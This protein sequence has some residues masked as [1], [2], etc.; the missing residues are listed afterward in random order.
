MRRLNEIGD[1][2]LE[3]LLAGNGP[4]GGQERD[5]LA[6]FIMQA[7]KASSIPP[8]PVT[9]ERHISAIVRT[10]QLSADKGEPGASPA[11][12]AFGPESQVSGLPKRR[13][14][15]VLNSV[16][17]SLVAKVLAVGMVLAAAT[18]ALAATGNLPDE[19]QN[20]IS[21]A[22]EALGIQIPPGDSLIESAEDSAEDLDDAVTDE[23]SKVA[24][25]DLL[26][27][28]EEGDEGTDSETGDEEKT[29]GGDPEAGKR[30]NFDVHAAIE[31]TE[32]GPERGKAVS[33]AARQK[34][35]DEGSGGELGDEE[36][37]DDAADE[38]GSSD[39]G[40]GTPQ[41]N[42]YGHSKH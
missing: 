21:T 26:D 3:R 12:K 35:G 32:P 10:A 14:N 38:N 31:A 25:D 9:V 22:A 37:V 19:V 28:T 18:G 15:L 11:S 30:S 20:Q 2:E 33:E 13:R 16:F 23:V 4:S 27:D 36:V 41:G 40:K 39:E 1:Q 29:Q 42:A 6:Y 5:D 8:S 34:P 17:T 24:D 7:K